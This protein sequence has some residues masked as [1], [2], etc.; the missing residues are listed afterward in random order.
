MSIELEMLSNHLI[1]FLPLFLLPSVFSSES[2][3]LINTQIG[4]RKL[5]VAG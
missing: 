5:W 3:L 4:S 2:D 1:F